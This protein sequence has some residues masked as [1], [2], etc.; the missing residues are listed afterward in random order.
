MLRKHHLLGPGLALFLLALAL[1]G[2]ALAKAPPGVHVDPGSPAAKEYSIPLSTARGAPAG[3]ASS[4]QLFGAG[5]TKGSGGSGS[6]GGSPPPATPAAPAPAAPAASTA[7]PHA[8][9]SHQS[10][11]KKRVAHRAVSPVPAP[12]AASAQAASAAP[13]SLKVLHP[14][15]GSGV[16]WMLGVACLVL[17]L[18]GLG[19]FALRGRARRADPR[20][21]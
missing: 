18:G 7:K 17:L 12:V 19:A 15:S 4:G 20:L 21:G 3:S 13:S 5:I 14:S 2:A 6:S 10:H 9:A 1:P 11:A 8:D 16:A